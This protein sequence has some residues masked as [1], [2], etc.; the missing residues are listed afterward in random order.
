VPAIAGG[1]GFGLVGLGAYH[2]PRNAGKS[3]AVVTAGITIIFLSTPMVL[4]G[5]LF[6]L[7][8]DIGTLPELFA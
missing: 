4:A 8:G 3:F 2:L 1:I 6:I 7:T 5:F